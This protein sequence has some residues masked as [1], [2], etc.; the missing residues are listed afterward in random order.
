[1]LPRAIERWYPVRDSRTLWRYWRR[2]PVCVGLASP[3]TR[4]CAA[5]LH[6]EVGQGGYTGQDLGR[7]SLIGIRTVQRGGR[8]GRFEQ[9][10]ELSVG[11]RSVGRRQRTDHGDEPWWKGRNEGA[12]FNGKRRE[13]EVKEEVVE[14]WLS[15]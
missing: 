8:Y 12:F 1:M 9:R 5:G 11:N 13:P 2:R 3:E 4:A 10:T 15:E 7:T 14:T 6:A